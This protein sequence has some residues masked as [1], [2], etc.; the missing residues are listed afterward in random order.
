[1]RSFAE[2]VVSG[3]LDFEELLRV[4]NESVVRLLTELRGVGLWTGQIYHIFV[5]NRPDVLPM[6]DA[7]VVPA[8]RNF[9]DYLQKSRRIRCLKWRKHGGPLE[10][11]DAG[12]F[13]Y[14]TARRNEYLKC[15]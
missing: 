3:R 6:E 8:F 12:I 13:G 9:T 5:L 14:I 7:S 10:P 15:S 1:M 4:E 2:V 11:K